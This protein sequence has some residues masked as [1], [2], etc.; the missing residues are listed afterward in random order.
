MVEQAMKEQ[1]KLD[2]I[3]E[4]SNREELLLDPSL[5]LIKDLKQSLLICLLVDT[6]KL[7][8]TKPG[9]NQQPEDHETDDD[10]NPTSRLLI[11]LFLYKSHSIMSRRTDLLQQLNSI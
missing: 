8:Q 4:L 5:C 9:L 7:I 6:V 2:S 3:E 10:D 11:Y 1:E